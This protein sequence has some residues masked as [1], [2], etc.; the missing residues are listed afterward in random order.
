MKK[1]LLNIK[2]YKNMGCP[3]SS[4]LAIGFILDKKS[5]KQF[6][7]DIDVMSVSE[8]LREQVYNHVDSSYVFCFM[9][10]GKL[11]YIMDDNKFNRKKWNIIKN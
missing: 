5:A 8:F 11:L 7:D 9:K 2:K 10:K 6:N 3:Y 4:R 1:L